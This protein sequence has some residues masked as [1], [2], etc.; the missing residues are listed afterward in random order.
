[1]ALDDVGGDGEFEGSTANIMN[2]IGLTPCDQDRFKEILERVAEEILEP[3]NYDGLVSE[4]N[5]KVY[6]SEVC[7]P[8]GMAEQAAESGFRAGFSFR[9]II[10]DSGGGP[11]G[12]SDKEMRD[13][14]RK[15][16]S[17]EKPG[18]IVVWPVC[19]PSGQLQDPKYMAMDVK[20]V[21]DKLRVAM[22]QMS[23]RMYMCTYP[24]HHFLHRVVR[25][26][27]EDN[28][29]HP[30]S[31]WVSPCWESTRPIVLNYKC[32][33]VINTSPMCCTCKH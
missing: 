17:C 26:S 13:R 4:R 10:H 7:S 15:K 16:L 3:R 5:H 1:M 21:E 31:R 6:V 27:G 25:L 33:V 2:T 19:G 28:H 23:P 11:W 8:P 32:L 14:A 18:C 24:S 22:T 29:A 12:F 9:L 20:E 30:S